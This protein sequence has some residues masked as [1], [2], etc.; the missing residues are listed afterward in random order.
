MSFKLLI[1][2]SKDIDKLSIDFSDGSSVVTHSESS[3]SSDLNE[4]I[5]NKPKAKKSNFKEQP[6]K[7]QPKKRNESFLDTD[8]IYADVSQDVIALPEISDN[9]RPVKVAEEIQNL[10][11]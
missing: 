5:S 10:E 2:C 7:E 3:G 1:E 4:T 9:K 6:K 11:L 8:E